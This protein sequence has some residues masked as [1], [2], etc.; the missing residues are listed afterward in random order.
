MDRE[1]GGKLAVGGSCGGLR[2]VVSV[3]KA[4]GLGFSKGD[5]DL[6]VFDF[7]TLKLTSSMALPSRLRA[8]RILLKIFGAQL[9]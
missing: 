3:R 2:L 7:Q 6:N 8:K 4:E 1:G 9:Q 5:T